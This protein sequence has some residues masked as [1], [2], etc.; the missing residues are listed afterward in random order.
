MERAADGRCGGQFQEHGAATEETGKPWRA[1]VRVAI[2]ARSAAMSAA[3]P[4]LRRHPLSRTPL[5]VVPAVSTGVPVLLD[6]LPLE[7]RMSQLFAPSPVRRTLGNCRRTRPGLGLRGPT[8]PLRNSSVCGDSLILDP[9]FALTALPQ[10][11]H[12]A[13]AAERERASSSRRVARRGTVPPGPAHTSSPSPFHSRFRSSEL[14]CARTASLRTPVPEACWASREERS[15]SDPISQLIRAT[16][17]SYGQG[18]RPHRPWGRGRDRNRQRGWLGIAVPSLRHLSRAAAL[19]RAGPQ[20]HRTEIRA[21]S[22]AG[23]VVG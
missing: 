15:P 23:H 9:P 20:D 10:V 18:H 2:R 13:L 3:Q 17:P 5:A 4:P 11:R 21:A 22:A 16:R 1:G 12:P 7:L 14:A 19:D 6:C 8:R